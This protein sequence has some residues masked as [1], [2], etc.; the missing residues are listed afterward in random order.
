MLLDLHVRRTDL[1][2]S[3]TP[4]KSNIIPQG[5]VVVLLNMA[6]P[7]GSRNTPAEIKDMYVT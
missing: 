2:G 5:S 3:W 4:G 6:H 1:Y 7:H